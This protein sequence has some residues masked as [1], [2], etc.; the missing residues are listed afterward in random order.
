ME[1]YWIDAVVLIQASNKYYRL[2]RVPKFWVFLGRELQTGRIKSPKI[3]F[4]EITDGHDILAD[5]VRQRREKGLCIT[6]SREVQQCYAQISEHVCNKYKTHQ[7]AEFLK[8]GDG[9]VIAHAMATGGTVVTEETAKSKKAKVKIPTV[10]RALNV[11]CVNT[12]DMLEE[13]EAGEF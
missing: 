4:Q 7:A 9:W 12:F 6:A 11:R 13:L 1:P 10:C 2:D 3:V 5:W 8:G